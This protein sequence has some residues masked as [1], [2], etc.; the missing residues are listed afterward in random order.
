[1]P[2]VGGQDPN[3]KMEEGEYYAIETFGSTGNGWVKNDVGHLLARAATDET[4]GEC[5]HYAKN[6][7]TKKRPMRK[8]TQEL[9]RTINEQFGSL[10][11]CRRY[12]DRTGEKGYLMAVSPPSS[13]TLD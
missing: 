1:M 11:F 8:R 13:L 6:M 12:L 4:Q 9:M 2:I 3:E 7:D 5:S 10:P